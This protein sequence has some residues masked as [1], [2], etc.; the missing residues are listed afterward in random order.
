M[1]A[2]GPYLSCP[3]LVYNVGCRRPEAQVTGL[4]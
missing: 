2:P 3:L 4:L 1:R